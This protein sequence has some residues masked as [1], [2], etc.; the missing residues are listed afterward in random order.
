M[1][2]LILLRKFCIWFDYVFFFLFR[3]INYYYW[4]YLWYRQGV[5]VYEWDNLIDVENK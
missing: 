2:Y 4:G 3:G 5:K 1:V